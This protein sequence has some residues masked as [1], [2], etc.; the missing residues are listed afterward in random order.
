MT[1]DEELIARVREALEFLASKQSRVGPSD[2]SA[3]EALD[4][5]ARRLE[6]EAN[7][8]DKAEAYLHVIADGEWNERYVREADDRDADISVEVFARQALLHPEPQEVKEQVT[9]SEAM[10][11]LN[12]KRATEPYAEEKPEWSCGA[13]V[14][15]D[16]RPEIGVEHRI[17]NG[18]R[19]DYPVM[20]P[21][22]SASEI[23]DPSF[24]IALR[25]WVPRSA[26]P[27]HGQV[28][29]AT[30]ST[31]VERGGEAD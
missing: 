11:R 17:E 26:C 13:Y 7:R 19:I 21:Q 6:E 29:E 25:R 31:D 23:M 4:T 18:Q 9:E 22:F 1:S 24:P 10:R 2:D 16:V 14:Y 15:D 27:E 5:L 8:A 28:T 12:E 3:L 30:P 20:G